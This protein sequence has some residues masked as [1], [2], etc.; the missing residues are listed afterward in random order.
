[1]QDFSRVI[2]FGSAKMKQ[3]NPENRLRKHTRFHRNKW[4]SYKEDCFFAKKVFRI[5]S[6][7]IQERKIGG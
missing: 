2:G 6:C 1:M 4:K 5:V 7:R 3:E